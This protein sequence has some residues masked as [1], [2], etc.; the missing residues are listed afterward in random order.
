MPTVVAERCERQASVAQNVG[1]AAAV[2]RVEGRENQRKRAL[3]DR[4]AVVFCAETRQPLNSPHRQL[5]QALG[6]ATAVR[7]SVDG[8]QQPLNARG[9]AQ[10]RL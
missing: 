8:A 10:V 7:D 5:K 1:V 3:G 2:V 4:H 6:S 9:L